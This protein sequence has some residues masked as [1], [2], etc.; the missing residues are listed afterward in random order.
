M[1]RLK[2][3][4]ARPK[5]SALKE[6]QRL[7]GDP[8]PMTVYR[9]FAQVE[10]YTGAGWRSGSVQRS[11]PSRCMIHLAKEQRMLVCT[12]NRNVRAKDK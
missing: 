11:D 10:V 9:R 6:G 8:T 12:D 1:R 4:T 5:P 3:G 7:A 2:D